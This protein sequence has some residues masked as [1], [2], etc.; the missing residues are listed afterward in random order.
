MDAFNL[1][2][3]QL[4]QLIAKRCCDSVSEDEMERLRW[5]IE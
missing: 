2:I 4:K 3:E 5:R 1:A